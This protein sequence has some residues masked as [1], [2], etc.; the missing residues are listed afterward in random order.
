MLGQT[1]HQLFMGAMTYMSVGG[2]YMVAIAL[3][4]LLEKMFMFK[5]FQRDCSKE[6][7]R[8]CFKLVGF[9]LFWL[10]FATLSGGFMLEWC[11]ADYDSP[12][13]SLSEMVGKII[14]FFIFDDLWFYGYHRL[15]HA[16]PW[17]YKV[18]HKPH[19]RFTAPFPAVA[20]YVHP[21]EMIALSIGTCLLPLGIFFRKTHPV[22]F[23]IWL[24][25][26]QLQVIEDHLGY[27]LPWSPT[28]LF[29]KTLVGGTKFHDLHHQK[30]KCNYAAMFSII[31]DFFGTAVHESP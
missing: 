30:F 7:M 4:H 23:W 15:V 21:G 1:D 19:H 24:S 9:N 5:H 31:D 27:E 29:P 18:L 17:L 16:D 20:Y 26:R 22:L 6:E 13:P 25:I 28:N 8:E 12:L 11:L 3:I 2:T 10:F 14:L